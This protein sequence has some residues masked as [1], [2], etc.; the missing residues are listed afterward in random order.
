MK[1]HYSGQGFVDPPTSGGGGGGPAD[2]NTLTN[3]PATFPGMIEVPNVAGLNSLTAAQVGETNELVMK[4]YTTA[5][6]SPVRIL[7]RDPSDTTTTGN[8]ID[9]FVDSAGN[10]WKA[11]HDF[12]QPFP[13][14]FGGGH[15]DA[16][17]NDGALGLTRIAGTLSHIATNTPAGGTMKVDWGSFRYD[18]AGTLDNFAA[19]YRGKNVSWVTDG[20]IINQKADARMID[21]SGVWGNVHTVTAIDNLF[22]DN[23]NYNT[24]QVTLASGGGEYAHGDVIKITSDDIMDGSKEFPVGSGTFDQHLT[25]EFALVESVNGNNLVLK[26][27]LQHT[28]ATNIIVAKWAGTEFTS[29]GVLDLT[30]DDKT[31]GTNANPRWNKEGIALR[32]MKVSV[33][34][35]RG[36]ELPSRY[37]H[38]YACYGFDVDIEAWD[39]ADDETAGRIGYAVN[40]TAC[41]AGKINII[42]RDVRHSYTNSPFHS[43][44]TSGDTN[45]LD[46]SGWDED[47]KVTGVGH[48]CTSAAFDTHELAARITFDVT[49]EGS[50]VD[51]QIR[52]YNHD[53]KC[54]TRGGGTGVLFA[55]IGNN[56]LGN[57][58]IRDSRIESDRYGIWVKP[59]TYTMNNGVPKITCIDSDFISIDRQACAFENANGL[60]L[61]CNVEAKGSGINEFAVGSGFEVEYRNLR[62]NNDLQTEPAKSGAGKLTSLDTAVSKG[63]IIVQS[64][65]NS[66]GG[67]EVPLQLTAAPTASTAADPRVVLA[68]VTS[69]HSQYTLD[70]PAAGNWTRYGP[71]SAV[72]GD[73]TM[74]GELFYRTPD[75]SADDG[76]LHRFVSNTGTD[77]AG[78]IVEIRNINS[79]TDFIWKAKAV[80]STQLG[81]GDEI[82]LKL[83]HMP[84]NALAF[85]A[86][87]FRNAASTLT[88]NAA[89]Q[90]A[91]V[92]FSGANFVLGHQGIDS[93]GLAY[94]NIEAAATSNFMGQVVIIY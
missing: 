18:I 9:V 89:T 43:L 34:G 90:D 71:A 25:G 64:A 54:F 30:S 39:L 22:A 80:H 70:A 55:S 48:G 16:T 94:A 58:I 92:A 27:R 77:K 10:R 42:A 12:S 50:R 32:T 57:H 65:S 2:W 15:S 36:Y 35:W 1:M 83:R 14:W 85:F 69:R 28:Y 86:G 53:V 26:T 81:N 6:D 17:G 31:V 5:G 21:Y 37:F 47:I 84:K 91:N 88:L 93:G 76:A 8:G 51:V 68:F 79:E 24:A 46:W 87:S 7:Y 49:T 38:M 3:K 11:N 4:G 75:G 45:K 23:P 41:R 82:D 33:K 60:L 74:R 62:V 72:G 67:T 59:H 63:P 52:G 44:L 66:N 73:F 29:H 56:S 13:V 78:F 19:E 40:T 20:A 61:N